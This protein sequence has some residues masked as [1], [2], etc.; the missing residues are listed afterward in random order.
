MR[1]G[2]MI[3]PQMDP[4]R[5]VPMANRAEAQGFDFLACGEHVF[6]HGPVSN[7]FV[8]LAAAAGATERIRLMTALTVLP[9]YPTALVAKLISTLDGVSGGRVEIG[10]GLGGEYPPEFEACGV[11]VRERGART[12]EALTILSAMFAGGPVH[13]A[14]RFTTL[15]GQRL[16]PLP[17]QRPR[18]PFWVGGRR[19]VSIRR[20][21]RHGD[22]WLPY[23]VTP[24]QVHDGLARAR[25]VAVECGRQAHDVRGG[26]FCWST[27]DADGSWARRT[28]ANVVGSI[29]QQDFS[30]S[31][32][33]YLV[34]GT[35]SEVGARMR[36]YADAGAE[37]LVF[38]PA[39]GDSDLDRV[40]D[41]FAGGVLP[42]LR[43]LVSG[44][45]S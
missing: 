13:H 24:D 4:R 12:D 43:P 34:G 18:P 3:P 32:D 45:S 22:G 33:R 9:I 29:Y 23:L 41:T 20:T 11:P 14:G 28:V 16:E 26:V 10:I 38:A 19:E 5:A 7:A 25:D 6:F 17:L 35:P 27:V 30:T 42:E 8:T 31:G 21:G 15:E 2:L 37:T 36:E 39:C 40:V 1:V 44:V